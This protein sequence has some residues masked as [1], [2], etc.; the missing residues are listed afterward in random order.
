MCSG[1]TDAKTGKTVACLKTS[2]EFV[3]AVRDEF[4]ISHPHC[5]IPVTAA[6]EKYLP[7]VCRR[8]NPSRQS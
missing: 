1:K 5:M 6:A 8:N 7:L 4:G 2:H 3:I